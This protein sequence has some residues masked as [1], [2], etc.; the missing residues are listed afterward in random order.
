MVQ[1]LVGLAAG[2]LLGFG[3]GFLYRK[4]IAGANAQSIEARAQ[5]AEAQAQKTLLAAEREADATAKQAMAEAKD[6]IAT[7]RRAV[8]ERASDICEICHRRRAESMH[9]VKPKS[10][11]GIVS[12]DNSIAVDGSGTTGCHGFAQRHEVIV[13][14]VVDGRRI[15]TPITDAARKWIRGES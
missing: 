7:I 1:V 15:W 4:S 8:F 13:T 5:A 3:A 12:L 11:G 14:A 6:E 9:E 2:L 10:L